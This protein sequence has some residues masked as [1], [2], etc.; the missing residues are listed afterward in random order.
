MVVIVT[1]IRCAGELRCDWLGRSAIS[2]FIRTTPI[3]SNFIFLILLYYQNVNKI[4]QVK[5]VSVLS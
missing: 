1:K 4:D 2:A 5:W 3:Y